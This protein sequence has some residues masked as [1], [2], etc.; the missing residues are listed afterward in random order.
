VAVALPLAVTIVLAVVPAVLGAEA[1]IT[2]N[3]WAMHGE[4]KVTSTGAVVYNVPAW[5]TIV[6]LRLAVPPA[7]RELLDR[8]ILPLSNVLPL[9]LPISS[10]VVVLPLL[11]PLLEPPEVPATVANELLLP[12]PQALSAR[13]PASAS[14]YPYLYIVF[15]YS[16][17]LSVCGLPACQRGGRSIDTDP[18]AQDL[19]CHEDQ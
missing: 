12:P 4:S 7:D 19:R 1:A 13:A 14:R 17:E 2:A 3:P 5:S 10:V 8:A 11:E 9:P 18:F 15:T 16:P 6:T